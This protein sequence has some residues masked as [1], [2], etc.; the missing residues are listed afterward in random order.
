MDV[1]YTELRTHILAIAH[2]YMDVGTEILQE[3]KI[4]AYQDTVHPWT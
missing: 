3:H 1:L 2:A 4:G